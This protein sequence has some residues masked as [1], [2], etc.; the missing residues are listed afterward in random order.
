MCRQSNQSPS[1]LLPL[2]FSVPLTLSLSVSEIS[3][4]S[5]CN[6]HFCIIRPASHTKLYVIRSK[7][8]VGS[9]NEAGGR[10]A[11]GQRGRGGGDLVR[12]MGLT[13]RG[14]W[15][16]ATG[17]ALIGL[18]VPRG[19]FV[20]SAL[21]CTYTCTHTNTHTHTHTFSRRNQF[22]WISVFSVLGFQF[23]VFSW[24]TILTKA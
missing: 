17:N 4:L 7:R 12:H 15:Q 9:W 21:V 1:R 22:I 6:M 18:N 2:S 10:G 14:A 8:G 13:R 23:S 11:E 3:R 24:P 5:I 16:S 19:S 20:E